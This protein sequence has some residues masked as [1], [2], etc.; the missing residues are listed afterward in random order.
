MEIKRGCDKDETNTIL[1]CFFSYLLK[2]QTMFSVDCLF[3]QFGIFLAHSLG[4]GHPI[5][6]ITALRQPTTLLYV[7]SQALDLLSRALPSLQPSTSG[8]LS[9]VPLSVTLR[10]LLHPLFNVRKERC[11]S[12]ICFCLFF[13]ASSSCSVFYSLCAIAAAQPAGRLEMEPQSWSCC[14]PKPTVK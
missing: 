5:L 4:C 10:S 8:H 9:T 14:C 3:C 1:M 2:V 6:D 11:H 13:P 12:H 7:Q